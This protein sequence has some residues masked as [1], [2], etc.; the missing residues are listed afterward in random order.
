[1]DFSQFPERVRAH[2]LSGIVR[3]SRRGIAIRFGKIQ[4]GVLPLSIRQEKVSSPALAPGELELLARRTFANLPY[5]LRI[6]VS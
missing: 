6:N 5:D 3:N 1:M 2:V 4:D